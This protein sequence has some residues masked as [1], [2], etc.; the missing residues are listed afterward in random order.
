VRRDGAA[1]TEFSDGSGT[2]DGSGEARAGKSGVVAG[3]VEAAAGGDGGGQPADLECSDFCGCVECV[4]GGG[5]GRLGART[6]RRLELEL[7]RHEDFG[8][9]RLGVRELDARHECGRAG[10]PGRSAGVA[11]VGTGVMTG[12]YLEGYLEGV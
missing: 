11:D 3:A 8:V 1:D 10:C 12:R 4:R 9:D 6:W 5:A 7:L 2:Y